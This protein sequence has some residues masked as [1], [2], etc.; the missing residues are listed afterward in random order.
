MPSSIAKAHASTCRIRRAQATPGSKQKFA[1]IS[2]MVAFFPSNS[3]SP[4][5]NRNTM[6]RPKKTSDAG[7][8]KLWKDDV[9][10]DHYALISG[11]SN[12]CLIGGPDSAPGASAHGRL[13]NVSERGSRSI[14]QKPSDNARGRNR[15]K[16]LRSFGEIRM[17]LPLSRN[18]GCAASGRQFGS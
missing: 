6:C 13:I 15:Q 14:I 5:S 1:I 2:V 8:R 7:P 16:R 17:A 9:C 18:Y 4:G 11:S 12:W 3:P 10:N